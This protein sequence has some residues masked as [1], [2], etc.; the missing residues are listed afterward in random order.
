MMDNSEFTPSFFDA[1]SEAWKKNKIP[2][3]EGSYKYKKN[4]FPPDHSEP[5]P[6]RKT[7]T[8]ALPYVEKE[9]PMLRRSKR[10]R[11]LRHA[12]VT[13]IVEVLTRH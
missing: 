8:T 3:G 10:I 6:P 2:F 4:A 5:Q 9:P 1:S 11:N 12:K 7:K 13:G